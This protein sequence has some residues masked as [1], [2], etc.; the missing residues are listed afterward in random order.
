MENIVKCAEHVVTPLIPRENLL[1]YREY[2]NLIS[3][4]VGSVHIVDGWGY[5]IHYGTERLVVSVDGKIFQA[6]D[7]LEEKVDKLKYM[8]KIKI[9]KIRTNIKRHV[10]YAVCSVFEK[11][12]WT[13]SVE[14]GNVPILPQNEMD[15]ETCVLDVR[16]VEVKGQKRKLL[17]TDRGFGP[18][19]YK[20]KKSKLEE[21]IEVGF[22]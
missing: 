20:L 17:L 1:N 8:C 16:T 22:I 10:K 6:G 9:E 19:V 2:P 18:V 7:D 11:G 13:V 15:G 5:I 12:D 4:G 3:L 21:N 14:Y